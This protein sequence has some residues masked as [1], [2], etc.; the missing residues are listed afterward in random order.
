LAE[1]NSEFEAE[2]LV[3]ALTFDIIGKVTL[4]IDMNAQDE[5]TSKVHPVVNAF[6]DILPMFEFEQ[7][8]SLIHK[9]YWRYKQYWAEKQL[10]KVLGKIIREKWDAMQTEKQSPDETATKDKSVLA[11]A[12]RDVD[13]M[14]DSVARI[15][16]S[17][18]RTFIFAGHDT[19]TT[20]LQWATYHLSTNESAKEALDTEMDDVFGDSDVFEVLSAP[21]GG[22]YLSKL[23]YVS[24]I[25]KESLRLYPPASSARMAPR[26]TGFKLRLDDDSE[27]MADEYVLYVSHFGIHRDANAYGPDVEEWKPERWFG[28]SE[29][30]AAQTNGGITVDGPEEGKKSDQQ[31]PA[32]AWRP[33]ERG[34]R[35]CI[36][37]ELANIEAKVILAC[38]ARR[39]VFE[40][41]GYGTH[42]G[43][44]MLQV[45]LHSYLK[46]F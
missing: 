28:N 1:S 35:N 18:L 46:R 45:S 27:M 29:T 14:N 10:E 41:V 31:I 20:M 24:A 42:E 4:G 21:D 38:M 36:G 44:P 11:L 30:T 7:M 22:S 32:S 33:F 40:K 17:Q 5:D 23:P 9:P 39:Y 8:Y 19:T 3:T 26:G 43:E 25:I 37:Q 34:A 2:K 6:Q 16:A 15:V 12:L 13:Q